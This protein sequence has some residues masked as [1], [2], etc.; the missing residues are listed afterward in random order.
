MK[1]LRRHSAYVITAYHSR[2]L[3]HGH[4]VG[5]VIVASV[6]DILDFGMRLIRYAGRRNAVRG[7]WRGRGRAE[8]G[9]REGRKEG[10]E[11]R[12]GKEVLM[13]RSGMENNNKKIN[14]ADGY[15]NDDAA[16]C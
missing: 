16:A 10:K 15:D 2:S 7:E 9:G 14:P 6:S 8:Q 4:E 3:G 13:G 12:E 11:G 5:S 1:Y